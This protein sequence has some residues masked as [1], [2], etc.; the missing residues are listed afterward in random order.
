MGL[1]GRIQINTFIKLEWL[2]FN[3]LFF[4]FIYTIKAF[5]A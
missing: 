2:Y 1:L 5:F 4:D 3:L